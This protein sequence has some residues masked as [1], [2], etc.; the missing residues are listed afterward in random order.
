LVGRVDAFGFEVA[1]VDA[2]QAYGAAVV[3]DE[4]RRVSQDDAGERIEC[5]IALDE[6]GRDGGRD[7]V[8]AAAG[9]LGGLAGRRIQK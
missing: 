2:L 8:R 3:D 4:R 5:V 1:G 7:V 6:R 9:E